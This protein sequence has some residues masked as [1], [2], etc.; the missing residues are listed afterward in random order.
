MYRNAW[1][2]PAG[3]PRGSLPKFVWQSW[4]AGLQKILEYS[5]AQYRGTDASERTAYVRPYEQT[6]HTKSSSWSPFGAP[7]GDNGKNWARFIIAGYIAP[8][9]VEDIPADKNREISYKS[10]RRQFERPAFLCGR[11]V[12]LPGSRI[13]H[14]LGPL[15]GQGVTFIMIGLPRGLLFIPVALVCQNRRAIVSRAPR[16]IGTRRTGRWLVCRSG[17]VPSGCP[18]RSSSRRSGC[19]RSGSA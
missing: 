17:P 9:M 1:C 18:K 2:A 8:T 12:V 3:K 14:S 16:F 11:L 15:C 4:V 13:H 10:W 19:A 5:F 6:A 7:L